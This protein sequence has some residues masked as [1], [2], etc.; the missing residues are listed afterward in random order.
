VVRT[1]GARPWGPAEDRRRALVK[2]AF[3]QIAKKG[4][5]GLRLRDVAEVVGIDH[6]TLHHYFPAKE[7]LIAGVVDYATSQFWTEASLGSSPA[8]HLGDHLHT[9]GRML[10]ERPELFIVLREL[11]LR[12]TRDAKIR[13]I[14][15]SREQGWRTALDARLRQGVRDPRVDHAAT[16]E[17]IIVAIKGATF[18]PDRAA[19]ALA[20]LARLLNPDGDAH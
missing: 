8:E 4:M 5:E 3:G 6:S 1:T 14:V 18:V 19:A 16:V 13:A 2:A 15:E 12:A 10:Q 11:D 7:D 20:Q 17:L 9:I